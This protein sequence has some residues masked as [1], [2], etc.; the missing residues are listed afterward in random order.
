MYVSEY[1]YLHMCKGRTGGS[2]GRMVQGGRK[3]REVG[4]SGRAGG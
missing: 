3:V 4:K 2:G 1:T